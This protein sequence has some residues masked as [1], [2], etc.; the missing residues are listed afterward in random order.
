MQANERILELRKILGLTQ[1]EFGSKIGLKQAIIGQMEKG[2]R[3][4]TDRTATL[5]CEKYNVNEQW[6]RTG[7]GAMFAPSDDSIIADVAAKYHLGELDK[8]ILKIFL[9]L[10]PEKR[11]ILHQFTRSLAGAAISELLS[12]QAQPAPQEQADLDIEEELARYR[13]ELELEK[14]AKERSEALPNS[15]EA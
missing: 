7:E 12:N 2:G 9:E 14:R 3:N 8:A 11:E 5:I 13:R 6:L 1:A 4:L 15:K 10:P